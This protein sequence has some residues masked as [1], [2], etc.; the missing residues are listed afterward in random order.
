V[1]LVGHDSSALARATARAAAFVRDRELV[2]LSGSREEL[3]LPLGTDATEDGGAASGW[4]A[5]AAAAWAMGVPIETIGTR[6][7]SLLREV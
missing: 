1:I 3:V 6:L 2:F 4:L 7:P 5:A